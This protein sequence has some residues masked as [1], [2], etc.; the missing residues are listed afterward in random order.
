MSSFIWAKYHE[1]ISRNKYGRALV[2]EI[3]DGPTYM[4][5]VFTTFQIPG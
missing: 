3:I 2:H 5:N 4:D 1:E